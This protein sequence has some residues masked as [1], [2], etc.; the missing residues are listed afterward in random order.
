MEGGEKFTKGGGQF[1]RVKKKKKKGNPKSISSP[2]S[3]RT[4]QLGPVGFFSFTHLLNWPLPPPSSRFSLLLAS[5]E[6]AS[7][8]LLPKPPATTPFPWPKENQRT[9]VPLFLCFSPLRPAI[10]E[11]LSVISLSAISTSTKQTQPENPPGHRPFSSLPVT[12]L[13]QPL[14][15]DP[16]SSRSAA[17]APSLSR[18]QPL[19]Q[20]YPHSSSP[21]FGQTSGV[22]TSAPPEETDPPAT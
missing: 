9:K 19:R 1:W 17:A 22:S 5:Q 14:T 15:T 13:P 16:R 18:L 10:S 6:P 4:P 20:T 21:P 8:P 12:P 2:S 3:R 7:P 11:P